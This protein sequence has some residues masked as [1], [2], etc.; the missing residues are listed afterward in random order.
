[1][2]EKPKSNNFIVSDVKTNRNSTKSKNNVPKKVYNQSVSSNNSINSSVLS[3]ATTKFSDKSSGHLI[4][5]KMPPKIVKNYKL[6]TS[7]R[8][9]TAPIASSLSTYK[10]SKVYKRL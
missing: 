4:T 2:Y 3:K 8:N 5:S 9:Q 7:N 1:M 10:Y 6:V